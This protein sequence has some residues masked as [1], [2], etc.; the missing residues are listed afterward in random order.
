MPKT[1][2]IKRH[3]DDGTLVTSNEPALILGEDGELRLVLPDYQDDNDIP[4]GALLLAAVL[5]RAEDE[6]W[7][8]EMAAFLLER[9]SDEDESGPL[10]Q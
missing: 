4:S 7:T 8:N 3:Q 2:S 9:Y 10:L 5:V 1:G 6:E